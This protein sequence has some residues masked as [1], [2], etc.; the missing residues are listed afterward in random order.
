MRII[1][2]LEFINERKV[3][4]VALAQRVA[5]RYGKRSSYGKW[6]KT[7]K[8]KHIPLTSYKYRDAE[9]ASNRLYNVQNKLGMYDRNTYDAGVKK[10]DS[11]HKKE[12][13]NIK[14]LRAT[15]PFV[16]T[17]DVEKLKAKVDNSSPDHIHVVTHKGQHYIADGHHAVMAAHLRGDKTVKVDHINLDNIK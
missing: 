11:M 13:M 6:E 4:P 5:S 7:E 16:R 12:T 15:Q 14:D 8:G 17:D 1:S 10:F 2:F 3:D 9:S